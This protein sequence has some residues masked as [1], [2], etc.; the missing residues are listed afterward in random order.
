M[1]KYVES[2]SIAACTKIMTL[3]LLINPEVP[4]PKAALFTAVA[5]SEY[6]RIPSKVCPLIVP[7]AI[8]VIATS[9]AHAPATAVELVLRLQSNT[10]RVPLMF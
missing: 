1:I 9:V 8:L 5:V 4:A 10:L 2:V 7:L 6:A 3:E